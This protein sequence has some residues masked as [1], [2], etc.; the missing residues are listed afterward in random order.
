[1][2]AQK[3]GW[4]KTQGI[5]L[6]EQVELP[7]TNVVH[8]GE[9]IG[10]EEKPNGVFAT[11]QVENQEHVRPS[12]EVGRLLTLQPDRS[13]AQYIKTEIQS[14][15]GTKEEFAIL[16]ERL[17]DTIEKL[18][19]GKDKDTDAPSYAAKHRIPVTIAGEHWEITLEKNSAG[20]YRLRLGQKKG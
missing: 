4:P 3:L 13:L 7:G 1:M 10:I 18:N 16:W 9:V 5:K 15:T 8:T 20:A 12:V 11:I 19:Q 6:G 2:R 17:E 14:A